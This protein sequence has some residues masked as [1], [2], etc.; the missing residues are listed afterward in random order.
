MFQPEEALHQ[1]SARALQ[2]WTLTSFTVAFCFNHTDFRQA[3]CGGAHY[4]LTEQ[5]AINCNNL[6][7]SIGQHRRRIPAHS[8]G[9]TTSNYN[10]E[11]PQLSDTTEHTQTFCGG[12]IN[13]FPLIDFSFVTGGDTVT[14]AFCGGAHTYGLFPLV[15]RPT[16]L[17][18]RQTQNTEYIAAF[19]G[20]A[21]LADYWIGTTIHWH[22]I[23]D[24]LTRHWDS[25]E[26]FEDWTRSFCGGVAYTVISRDLHYKGLH[27]GALG[28]IY[29][30]VDKPTT[31]LFSLWRS[32]SCSIY[33]EH[34]LTFCGGV[35]EVQQSQLLCTPEYTGQ[36]LT[37]CG[38]VLWAQ[39]S[40]YLDIAVNT[41][42]FLTFCGGVFR[43]QYF[44]YLC[45]AG[46]TVN[47][48]AFC[49][50]VLAT[51]NTLY[52]RFQFCPDTTGTNAD[53][54]LIQWIED[55]DLFLAFCGGAP[56]QEGSY[57]T[58]ESGHDTDWTLADKFCIA[59][60]A[61]DT[62]FTS[63]SRHSTHCALTVLTSLTLYST[64]S[65]WFWALVQL[66]LL[67]GAL[68]IFHIF[69]L[70]LA[71]A[72][73]ELEQTFWIHFWTTI[74]TIWDLIYHFDCLWKFAI[75]GKR[76]HSTCVPEC[77]PG[78]KSRRSWCTNLPAILRICLTLICMVLITRNGGEGSGST[79]TPD[80]SYLLHTQNL[81]GVKQHDLRPPACSDS[82][83]SNLTDVK[84]RS[85]KRA[86]KR[87]CLQGIA[88]YRGRLYRPDDF[89]FM[90]PIAVSTQ[91]K[92][93]PKP[94]PP[95]A[96]N[97]C[98]Q[99]HGTKSRL[100]CLQW[101]VGGLSTHRLDEIKTWLSQQQI[102]VVTLLE[103]RW[104]YTGEW[105][106]SQ[107]IHVHSGSLDD[108]GMGILTLI[109]R[110]LCQ[111]HA[112]RWTEIVVGRLIQLRVPL[113]N[114]SIDI[115]CG[116]QHVDKRGPQ[117]LQR[118]EHWW[119]SLD[120][121]LQGIPHRNMLM[122]MADFNTN[123]PPCTSHSGSDQYWW[124]DKLV[125]GSQHQDAGRLISILRFH[126]LVVLNSWSSRD[127]PTYV[128]GQ[129]SSR[130]DF[131]C[132]RKSQ[133]DGIA[134]QPR[135]LWGAPFMGPTQQGHVPIVHQIA[136]FWAPTRPLKQGHIS[137]QQCL[138][139]QAAYQ[140]GTSQWET[141]VTHS[142]EVMT[143]ALYQVWTSDQPQDTSLDSFHAAVNECFH[144][145][146]PPMS[147]PNGNNPQHLS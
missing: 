128:H 133:V 95:N 56:Q 96:L 108:R 19:C 53:S 16:G 113:H 127:G 21:L 57:Y 121:T 67:C 31:D 120:R 5:Q 25:S 8:G 22:R 60:V 106:D 136:L 88:W 99:I 81:P 32:S 117:C 64:A 30:R 35:S 10:C 122:L 43:G 2:D 9:A 27:C 47:F 59:G 131:G 1:H 41:G 115:V 135:Y 82:K 125:R 118:R 107:W 54:H 12:I 101:N 142:A 84:K 102:Q 111:P 146:F 38:G 86:Y 51:C 104:Q 94:L 137:K 20:G 11:E 90:P 129:H 58:G 89:H 134:K 39:Q 62:L 132:V 98:N 34:F 141:Y 66:C 65:D 116:Y 126:G 69:R 7:P 6:F 18:Y 143:R 74:L 109:S 15:P 36:F 85:L 114:R 103:T 93:K 92:A 144:T 52:R 97:Q 76:I 110:K 72:A 17:G 44:L 80:F 40:H 55:T 23:T 78:P 140:S 91:P 26:S 139:A 24:F 75:A 124:H 105:L 130:I 46:Y 29:H 145:H 119:G 50:G 61:T 73:L 100:T 28:T 45:I 77:Q 49:G 79:E 3:F 123:V 71:N 68:H 138:Q 63:P 37:F 112:L 70:S 13:R 33:T 48:S 42:L 4:R 83:S 14:F 147:A 87:A